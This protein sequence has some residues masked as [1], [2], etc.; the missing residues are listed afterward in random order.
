MT[1]HEA[2]LVAE[3]LYKLMK[4]DVKRHVRELVKEEQEDWL[5]PKQAADILG[6]SVSFVMHSS[7]PK[8]KVGRMNR[9]R[10]SDVVKLLER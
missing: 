1:Q 5:S 10:K 3:E 4:D 7:L 8:T 6:V 2:R 9:Y